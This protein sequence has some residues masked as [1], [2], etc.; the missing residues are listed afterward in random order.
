MSV[1]MKETLAFCRSADGS[2]SGE[3]CLH[4]AGG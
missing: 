2:P 3:G 4:P 1:G